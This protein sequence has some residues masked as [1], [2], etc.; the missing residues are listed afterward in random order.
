MA[1]SLLDR[2]TQ[3]PSNAKLHPNSLEYMR[4]LKESLCRDLTALLNT[5]R[6]EEDF[7]PSFDEP[8]NSL[9]TFGIADFTSLNLTNGADQERLRRSVERAIRQ[10]EPRLTQVSVTLHEPNT[11]NPVLR[12]HIEAILKIGLRR[13]PVLFS[14]A[15]AR[16][17]RRFAVS[18][19]G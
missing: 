12:L 3:S 13:E 5:R 18:G 2:L 16:D 8:T 1:F 14:A 19:A 10:F 11:A 9:L 4:S 6:A 15:L 7:D 17:L